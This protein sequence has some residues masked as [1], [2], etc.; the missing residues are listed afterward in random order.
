MRRRNNNKYTLG[1][2][3]ITNDSEAAFSTLSLTNTESGDQDKFRPIS[4]STSSARLS[5]D[6]AE[7]IVSHHDEE[8]PPTSPDVAEH[9][10]K[11]GGF[12]KKLL[13]D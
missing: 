1:H 8:T 12:L 4:P 9:R 11:R 7:S 2:G 5:K 13:K 10:S 6:G 3:R